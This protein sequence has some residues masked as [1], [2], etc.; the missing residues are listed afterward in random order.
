MLVLFIGVLLLIAYSAG[1]IGGLLA[2]LL[3]ILALIFFGD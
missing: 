2:I 1:K 3:F